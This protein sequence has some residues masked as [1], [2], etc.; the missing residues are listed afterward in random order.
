MA[1]TPAQRQRRSR[2]HRAGDHD[3][4]DA[5]R[6]PH[7]PQLPDVTP[8]TT[9]VTLPGLAKRGSDLW[10]T[11]HAEGP[12]TAA[13]GALLLE[14]CRIADRL[15][16]LDGILRGADDGWMRLRANDDGTEVTV[17]VDRVLAEARAQAVAL[18]QLVAEVRQSRGKGT[19]DQA[20]REVSIF[21]EL[22]ARREARRAAA[23]A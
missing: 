3:L 4:C 22:R 6:C 14:A 8:V 19:T 21:D 15:D 1:L 17:S 9:D 2:R 23:G 10:R 11:V 20:G 16:T 12:L 13:A 18:K 7:A 5:T